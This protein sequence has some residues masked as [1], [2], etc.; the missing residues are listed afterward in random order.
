L[1]NWSND[2]GLSSNSALLSIL[3]SDQ[4]ASGAGN[5]LPSSLGLSADVIRHSVSSGEVSV[6]VGSRSSMGCE[7]GLCVSVELLFAKGCDRWLLRITH[8]GIL[9]T[10]QAEADKGEHGQYVK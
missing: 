8:S 1:C 4:A 10:R 7:G 6:V 5:P 9:D 3:S 2:G